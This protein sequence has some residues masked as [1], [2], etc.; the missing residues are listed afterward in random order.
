MT[1]TI[2]DALALFASGKSPREC[3]KL[4][5][6][7]ATTISR[8]AKEQGIIKGSVAQLITDSV[9]V[10]V[11]VGAQNGAVKELIKTEVNK[12]LQGMEFY[13]TQ[14]RDAV[15]IGMEAL[16]QEPTVAGMKTA[17]EGMKT[18]MIVEGLVP[19]Y[20][21]APVINNTAAAQ[22]VSNAGISK[23]GIA[24]I[25]EALGIRSDW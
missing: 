24:S 10:A 11:E 18:G 1:K 16:K 2:D 3:E 22:S 7:P 9:R 25:H 20:P 8:K 12:Q 13:S 14:A 19:F 4:T 15:K 5:G 23:E 17:L 6:I 21:N